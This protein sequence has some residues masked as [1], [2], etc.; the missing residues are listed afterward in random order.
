MS[1][2]ESKTKRKYHYVTFH[3]E[4]IRTKE[5]QKK[6]NR[7]PNLNYV[8]LTNSIIIIVCIFIVGLLANLF[9]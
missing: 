1:V 3:G 4:D 9:I 2:S 6:I 5:F 8:I 7:K